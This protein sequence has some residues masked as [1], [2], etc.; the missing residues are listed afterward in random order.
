MHIN[1]PSYNDIWP[2]EK[3]T[4][5]VT[6]LTKLLTSHFQQEFIKNVNIL[7]ECKEPRNAYMLLLRFANLKNIIDQTNLEN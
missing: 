4:W 6:Y 5:K 2:N 1:Q 3:K 7:H